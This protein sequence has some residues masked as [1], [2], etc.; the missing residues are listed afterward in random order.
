MHILIVTQYFWPEN[1]RINDL[2]I[3]LKDRGHTITVLTGIPNY[4]GGKFFPGYGLFSPRRENYHGIEVLRVPLFPRGAGRHLTLI[5]NYLSFALLSSVLGPL[6]CRGNYD[7]IFI[8]EPS[9]ITVGLPALILKRLKDIPVVLW[10]Q[11]LWPESLSA[12]G[13]VTS[14]WLLK[15]VGRFVRFIYKGCDRILVQSR[16]FIRSI[17]DFG[18]DTNRI[19]YF[20]NSAEQMFQPTNPEHDA[21]ERAD[22]PDGFRV[23][24]AGNIGVSQDFETVLSAA[25][26][27]RSNTDIHW[28]VLGGGRMEAW[29][30]DQVR[31]RGL[32]GN[33]HLL[34]RR[35]Q[36]TMP[37]YFALA[38]VML[39]TLRRD[40]VFA[41]TIPSKVQSY[42]ACAR[43]IVAA[44]DGEGSRVVVESGAGIAAPSGDANALAEAIMEIYRLPESERA[45][46]GL[47]GRRYYEAHFDR[48][49]LLERLENWLMEL[50][51]EDSP[52]AV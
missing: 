9:P 46:M 47:C 10:V 15:I 6:I 3:G 34:G 7:V 11:D 14:S 12:T 18:I 38:D 37:R 44:L 32:E 29:L 13:A 30:K 33:V 8:F 1:F 26:I 2:A 28:V 23:M 31:K 35:P 39:V 27:L 19:G 45:E 48:N 21:T 5:A 41:L 17:E 42:L 16:A 49:R 4:P 36:E 24:F 52:E 20:P 22:V 40:P 50:V 43:P 25:G 51:E